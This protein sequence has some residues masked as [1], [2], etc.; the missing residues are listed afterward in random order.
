LAVIVALLLVGIG[1]LIGKGRDSE[2]GVDGNSTSPSEAEPGPTDEING[3]PVGYARTE[4]GALKA[5][6]N[7]TASQDICASD[8]EVCLDVM[9]TVAAPSWA[10]E[11]RA[12]AENGA[13]FAAERYGTSA[14]ASS[15]FIRYR[16]NSF[17]PNE[18]SVSLWSVS[19]FSGSK[20]PEGEAVW[21]IL[22]VKLSWVG[23]DW[24]VADQ[25][26]SPGPS[27][28]SSQQG[29]ASS[30]DSQLSGFQ[31]FRSDALP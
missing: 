19:V 4:E 28:S 13:E 18:A 26:S 12:Q 24:K 1:I 7:L 27:P 8:H 14:S 16:V 22:T 30:L 5:A 21:G 23:G 15:S 17:S 2:D 3:V 11:A 6:V 10:S 20:I 29:E 25:A 9:R 31:E